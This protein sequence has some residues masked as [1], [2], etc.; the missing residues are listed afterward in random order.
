VRVLVLGGDGYLGWPRPCTCPMSVT[1]WPCWT[2]SWRRQYDHEMGVQ[3]LVPIEPL[4]ARLD[5][6]HEV[7]GKRLPHSSAIW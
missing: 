7:S 1:R 3:S 5:A 2:I 4:Q 6:W